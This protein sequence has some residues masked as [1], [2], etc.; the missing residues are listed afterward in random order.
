MLNDKRIELQTLLDK[1]SLR[2]R[3]KNRTQY[4]QYG[5]KTVKI[6]ARTLK[7]QLP[8]T[9]IVKILKTSGEM[10]H[11]PQEISKTFQTYG[12]LHNI[13]LQGRRK[14]KNIE[15]IRQYI[16]ETALPT[17]PRK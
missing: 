13:N 10:T 3:D 15:E 17:L 16:N 14:K 11:D 6:L 5:N 8:L 7:Q 9:T 12:K 2:V 1:Q 4:Y